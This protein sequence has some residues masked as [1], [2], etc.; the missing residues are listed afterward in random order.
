MTSRFTFAVCMKCGV[1]SPPITNMRNVDAEL[2]GM[3][4]HLNHRRFTVL[5]TCPGCQDEKQKMSM[6]RPPA[7]DR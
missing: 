6:L 3:G 7:A 4:W 1:Q 5:A 2:K